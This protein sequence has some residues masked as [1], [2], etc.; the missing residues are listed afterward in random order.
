MIGSKLNNLILLYILNFDV[1]SYD[2]S[3]GKI[4]DHNSSS[5]FNGTPGR[6]NRVLGFCNGFIY[7]QYTYVAD[8]FYA[9]ISLDLS[10][11]EYTEEKDIPKELYY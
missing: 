8:E 5:L 11:V 9:R 3:T 6:M 10:T 2:L 1:K 4:I 7:Y